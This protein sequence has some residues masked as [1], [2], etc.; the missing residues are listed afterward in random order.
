MNNNYQLQTLQAIPVARTEEVASSSG[1]LAEITY[2]LAENAAFTDRL[3]AALAKQVMD[4][5][6]ALATVEAYYNQIA[7][8]GREEFRL[9]VQTY[10]R[11][12]L[13]Q[14][15]GGSPPAGGRSFALSCRPMPGWH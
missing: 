2:A 10:A 15:V 11:L 6:A 3:K 1:R 12:A 14:I 7:P 9:I 13:M 8:S 5:T 4:N